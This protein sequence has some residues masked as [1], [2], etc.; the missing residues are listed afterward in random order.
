[1]IE[2]TLL[3]RAYGPSDAP[4]LLPH[5]EALGKVRAAVAARGDAARAY[6]GAR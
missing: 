5:D 1:M 4:T 3:P 6:L 2:D